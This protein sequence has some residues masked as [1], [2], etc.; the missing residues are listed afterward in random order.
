MHEE[1]CGRVLL[2]CKRYWDPVKV[3]AAFPRARRGLSSSQRWSPLNAYITH[4]YV[5]SRVV[6]LHGRTRKRVSAHV[7]RTILIVSRN[8]NQ[9]LHIFR[10]AISIYS[11]ANHVFFFFSSF[12]FSLSR[13]EDFNSK[14]CH[15]EAEGRG[16]KRKL[17]NVSHTRGSMMLRFVTQLG[18]KE[19]DEEFRS[20]FV[21][22]ITFSKRILPTNRFK[23]ISVL[24]RKR[25]KKA[26]R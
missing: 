20:F 2:Q 17:R 12:S 19:M 8:V 18:R 16:R 23:N 21:F 14:F 25:L 1:T 9:L 22:E 15:P 6:L 26:S 10:I 11:R 13:K 3:S 24:D 7:L 4:G 5:I